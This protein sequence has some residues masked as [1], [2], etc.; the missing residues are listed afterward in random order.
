MEIC[1]LTTEGIESKREEL[2]ALS[3][4]ERIQQANQIAENFRGWTLENFEPT[5]MQREQLE[6]LPEDTNS[7]LGWQIASAVIIKSD[8]EEATLETQS[9]GSCTLT[10]RW[11]IDTPKIKTEGELKVT[12][13]GSG[14]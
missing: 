11:K 7:Y 8:I 4:D 1:P 2:Y 13:G 14:K 9:S 5:P 3:D 10:V 12:I 6:N